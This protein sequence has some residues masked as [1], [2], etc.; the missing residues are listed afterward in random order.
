MHNGA[1][2]RIL[3]KTASAIDLSVCFSQIEADFQWSIL[4]SPGDS[5]HCPIVIVYE[6]EKQAEINVKWCIK[7]AIWD[8]YRTTAAWT[9][10]PRSLENSSEELI[11]EVYRRINTA[12]SEAMRQTQMSKFFPSFGGD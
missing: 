12:A 7:K 9:N 2:T 6:E 3:Y 4:V 8:V 1:P 10:I 5:D 11:D